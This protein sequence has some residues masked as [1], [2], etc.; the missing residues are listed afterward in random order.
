MAVHRFLSERRSGVLLH[1]TSLPNSEQYQAVAE[2]RGQGTLGVDAYR[3]IDWMHEAGFQV[4]QMLPLGPTLEDRSPYQSLSSHAG[5]PD[6]ISL[7]WLHQQGW[8]RADDLLEPQPESGQLS[9]RARYASSFYRHLHEEA[10][11]EW[12]EAFNTFCLERSWWL[13]DFA[14][15]CALRDHFKTAP[16]VTWPEPLRKREAQT[17]E[18]Y[19]TLLAYEISVVL[20]E[21]FAFYRQ[22]SALKHYANSRGILL[23]GDIP[24]FVGHDSSD[25]W[26]GQENFL[27]NEDGYAKTVAGV[28]P[29]YFSATGQHWGNPHYDWEKMR[30]DGFTW[31]TQRMRTQAELFDLV[32]I[33]HFR[34]FESFWE[35]PGDSIDA[36]NGQWVRA[37]GRE[38]LS[39]LTA[40]LPTL[41]LVAEN[42]GLITDEVEAL[43]L[44]FDLPGMLILQFAFDSNP[45]NPHLPHNH[46]P[47]NIVYT[48]THDNDTSLGWW[49][50]LNE[51]QQHH[52]RRYCLESAMGLPWMLVEL[53]LASTARLSIIPLQDFL[54]LDGHARFNTPGTAKGNWSWQ[55]QW[56]D[57]P[58]DLSVRIRHLN[59]MF[60]RL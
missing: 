40:E 48:G 12:Y 57:I 26:A 53:A 6:L 49:Q 35:I 39:T 2:G 15:F 22:W 41:I 47:N 9:T 42:L 59:A 1:P 7:D 10:S 60:G 46:L 32:R 38:L 52:V 17:L 54:Q 45:D 30:S 33:D 31:W 23:F 5:N 55:F 24:M 4:W 11:T 56:H 20:F 14:L 13:N 44:D 8:V 51:H 21:Q 16:W 58:S 43:R 29:D 36:S 3:F 37:P 50:S 28:P 18:H 27:L 34:G 19:R 25:V